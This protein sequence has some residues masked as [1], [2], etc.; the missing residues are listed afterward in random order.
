M[1]PIL[2]FLVEAVWMEQFIELLGQNF[3]RSVAHFM[4]VILVMLRLQAH[5]T[6]LA[7]M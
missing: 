1:L 3:L 6:F 4:D 5:I 2:L 7:N